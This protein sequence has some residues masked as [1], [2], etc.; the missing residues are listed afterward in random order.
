MKIKHPKIIGA[1]SVIALAVSGGIAYE[2][3]KYHGSNSEPK[4]HSTQPDVVKKEA[5]EDKAESSENKSSSTNSNNNSS[6]NSETSNI[7]NNDTSW[8]PGTPPELHDITYYTFNAMGETIGSIE[9]NGTNI[10]EYAGHAHD[11]VKGTNVKY[12]FLGSGHYFFDY[13]ES[14]NGKVTHKTSELIMNGDT[15]LFG[16]ATF[17]KDNRTWFILTRP[18]W[19]DETDFERAEKANSDNKDDSNQGENEELPA[20]D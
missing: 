15:W 14:F 10:I 11:L 5:K 19:A 12:K 3:N 8:T 4:L 7:E 9:F 16:G 1:L 18:E 13:D 6:N 20:E 2:T 17:Y